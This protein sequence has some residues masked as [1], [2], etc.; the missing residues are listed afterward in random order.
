MT[1]LTNIGFLG[2]GS[3]AEAMV[4][5]I[6]TSEFVYPEQLI[7]MNR[8]N[9]A[10]LYELRKKYNVETTHCLKELIEQS[11]VIILAVKPIDAAHALEEIRPY[12]TD[13]HLVI[14]VLAGVTTS[15]IEE[16]LETKTPVVRAMP[17]TSAT[18]GASATAIS[19]GKYTDSTH[20]LFAT[21]L[22]E[23]IGTVALV[24]EDQLDAVTGLSGSGPAYFYYMVECMEKA[25]S[26]NG[27]DKETARSLILQT[28]TGAAEMLSITN[29][30]PSLLRERITSPG[31]TT[32]AALAILEEYQFE[33]AI[34]ACVTGATKRSKELGKSFEKQHD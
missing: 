11:N 27:L 7:L 17:N 22:F 16:S 6:I 29:H 24:P 18:I 26:A 33:E 28:I 3:M 19:P 14:S 1:N 8:S 20:S 2:A 12:M 30:S 9:S 21:Q 5:G 10:R 23:T 25:A 13:N 34:V 15:Y 32:Q 4:E 31:G